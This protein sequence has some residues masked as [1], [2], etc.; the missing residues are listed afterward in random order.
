MANMSVVESKRGT[1]EAES[2]TKLT[3]LAF[4]FIPLTFSAS[5]F[6]MQVKELD[7]SRKSIAAFFILAIIITTASY[8][9]R[10]L[11]RKRK[12][13]WLPKETPRG[14]QAGRWSSARFPHPYTNF[15]SVVV[16]TRRPPH[17]HRDSSGGTTGHTGSCPLD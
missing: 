14:Y 3:Q 16:A 9:L 8:A 11:I 7:A 10:L 4:L 12:L 2:V 15:H 6:S 13:H 17:H 5:I 1:A